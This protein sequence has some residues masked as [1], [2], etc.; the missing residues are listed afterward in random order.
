MDTASTARYVPK[1]AAIT[2]CRFMKVLDTRSVEGIK[3]K[4]GLVELCLDNGT[5]CNSVTDPPL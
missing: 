2:L 5:L 3:N 1:V 4:L